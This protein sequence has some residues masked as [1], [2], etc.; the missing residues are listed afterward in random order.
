VAQDAAAAGVLLDEVD[1]LDEPDVVE[2]ESDDVVV[3]VVVEDVPGS[4][5]VEDESAETLPL[6]SEPDR[7]SVR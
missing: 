1:E 6:P 5:P 2:P 7:L 4:E 3:S